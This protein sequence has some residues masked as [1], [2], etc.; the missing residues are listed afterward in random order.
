MASKL[1]LIGGQLHGIAS[2][3]TNAASEIRT[4]LENEFAQTA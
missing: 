1:T 4:S 3:A 2:N